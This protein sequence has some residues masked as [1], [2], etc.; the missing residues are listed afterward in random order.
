[1]NSRVYNEPEIEITEFDAK[2]VIIT[3]APEL[4]DDKFPYSNLKQ[5]K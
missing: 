1:M 5:L 3:S 4:E 2:D